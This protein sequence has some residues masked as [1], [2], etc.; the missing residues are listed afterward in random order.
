MTAGTSPARRVETAQK[1][2]IA[3]VKRMT[4]EANSAAERSACIGSS[5]RRGRGD[6]VV[7]LDESPWRC[8]RLRARRLHGHDSPVT[9]GLFA[10]GLFAVH[11]SCCERNVAL[12][13]FAFASECS[14]HILARGFKLKSCPVLQIV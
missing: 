4:N 8:A 10:R 13:V 7:R 14:R 11:L 12:A 5:Q 2:Q 1:C 6:L 9:V 3:P